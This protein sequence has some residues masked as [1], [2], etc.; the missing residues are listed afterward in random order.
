ML[1]TVFARVLDRTDES[2]CQLWHFG[3]TVSPFMSPKIGKQLETLCTMWKLDE[4]GHIQC[5]C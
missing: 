1:V 3:P 2:V 5:H 4:T